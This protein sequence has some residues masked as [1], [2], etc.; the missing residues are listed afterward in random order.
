MSDS[1]AYYRAASKPIFTYLKGKGAQSPLFTPF[2]N[3]QVSIP[4][5][6]ATTDTATTLNALLSAL[7]SVGI[8]AT[9]KEQTIAGVIDTMSPSTDDT[10]SWKRLITKNMLVQYLESTSSPPVT[11]SSPYDLL[12]DPG[13]SFFGHTGAAN[14]EPSS[15]VLTS[16]GERSA[17]Q[18]LALEWCCLFGNKPVSVLTFVDAYNHIERSRQF[19]ES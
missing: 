10:E 13:M 9:T 12:S 6:N 19:G 15:G 5:V 1:P 18:Q 11:Q 16:E 7:S 17:L 2:K 14:I 4:H 8:L 3:Q